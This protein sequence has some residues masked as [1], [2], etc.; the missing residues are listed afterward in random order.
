ML[1]VLDKLESI[2][3]KKIWREAISLKDGG[4]KLPITIHG[5]E[6]TFVI[7]DEDDLET[8]AKTVNLLKRSV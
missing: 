1:E 7:R 5:D 3:D 4:S 8:M 6:I 2:N